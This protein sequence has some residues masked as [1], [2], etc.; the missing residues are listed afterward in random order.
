MNTDGIDIFHGAY[1]N[2]I[3]AVIAHDFEFYFLPAGDAF[4]HEYLMDGRTMQP[5]LR[6]L[7]ELALRF[8]NTASRAA[9][10]KSGTH[11]HGVSD[12]M[13]GKIDGVLKRRYDFGRNARFA[14][15]Q[16][17]VFENLPVFRF[18]YRIRPRTQKLYSVTFQKARFGKLHAQREA[19]LPAE[20]RKQT[21]RLFLFDNP[22]NRFGNKR[23]DIHSIRHGSVGHERRGIRIDK[24]N[25]QALLFESF[26]RLRAR[27][28]EFGGLPDNDRPRTDNHNFMN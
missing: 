9:E 7:F 21:V 26:A 16:H 22:P 8:R 20:C 18:V 19:C 1:G 11:N 28:I 12:F 14:D 10:R 25:A 3:A 5:V 13:F 15:G 23:F 24:D 6:N 17:R 4:F 27:V 2:R